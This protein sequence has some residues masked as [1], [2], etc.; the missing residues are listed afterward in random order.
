[1][2][3]QVSGFGDKLTSFIGRQRELTEIKRMLGQSRLVILT[4]VGGVGKTRLALRAAESVRSDFQDGVWLVELAKVTDPDL[5]VHAVAEALGVR[6]QSVR[7]TEDLLLDFVA[8]KRLLLIMDNCEHLLEACATLISRLLNASEHLVVLA[9]SRETL[10]VFGEQ[11]WPVPPLSMPD[12]ANV[13]PSRGGYVYGHEA[14]DLFEERAK[15]VLPYFTLDSESRQAAAQLCQGLDGLPLAIELAAVRLRA[16]SIEQILERLQD[17]YRLLTG[18]NRGGPARHQTLRAAVDWSFG[19]CTPQE[20]A[21]WARLSI[22]AGGFDLEAAEEVCALGEIGEN[23]VLELLASLIDK[24][25]VL[26]AEGRPQARYWMLETIREY[27]REQL[28]AGGVEERFRRRHRDH[29][30]RLAERSDESWFGPDQLAWWDRLQSEQPNLWTALDFC[31]STSG[32]VGL[33]VHMAGALC[34]YWNACGHL[35]D[36]RFWLGRALDADERPTQARVKALWVIGYVAMT[37]GDNTAAMGYF[38][39]SD[40]LADRLGDRSAKAMTT[41]FRGS[42]EQFSGNLDRA[43]SLLREAV[44]FHR[45]AGVVNSLTVLGVAQLGFVR[46]LTGQADSAIELSEECRVTSEE[47]GEQWAYSWALWVAGLAR[48]TL[49]EYRKSANALLLSLDLKH[50]LNDRLGVSACVELLAWVAIE[51]GNAERAADLF[52][53]SHTSWA[54]VGAPLFGSRALMDTRN[55]YVRWTREVLG[56]TVFN[57]RERRGE[58]LAISDAIL[59][60][61][62]EPKGEC[63][64]QGLQD[65]LRLTRRER[66]VARLIADGLTNKGIA[67]RLVISQRTVEGHVEHVL[68]KMGVKSRTQVAIWFANHGADDPPD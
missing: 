43:E 65:Q 63:L 28:A 45:D 14:L 8:E 15:K 41:Q 46:C 10:G 39:E 56:D 51:E 30:L 36:G 48:W 11:S 19:L 54:T 37:Q 38:D 13:A 61:H 44:D 26:R 16:M 68:D 50:A 57:E 59:L 20:Q 25:I 49:G 2:S 58:Q 42:A 66:E 29:Y 67:S 24:S 62:S 12:L 22:F 31:L 17:R 3:A 7:S 60:A 34:F 1:M 5:L 40:E 35:R 4:G 18:G 23:D 32:E 47:H 21:L 9:T 64:S 6:D 27:G 53:T 33:G 55:R 52:G